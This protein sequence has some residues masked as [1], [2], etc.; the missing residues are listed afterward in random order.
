MLEMWPHGDAK[1]PGLI[2]GIAASSEEV[3]K[4]YNISSAL[5][6]AHMM[7]QF[8]HECSAGGEMK[9]NIRYSASRATQVWPSRFDDAEDCYRKCDSY[10]GDPQFHIKLIDH[11]YGGRMGNRP[12]PSHDGSQY[13]GM[14]LSQVT[15][16]EGYERLAAKTGLDLLDN[17]QL[18]IDP[19]HTLECGVADFIICGCLPYAE[20]DNLK[21]VTQRLNGG[22]IGAAERRAWLTHWK[23]ELNEL[24]EQKRSVSGGARGSDSNE[25]TYNP[26][27]VVA[28]PDNTP[29]TSD[30]ATIYVDP[31]PEPEKVT[32][33]SRFR[34]G[35]GGS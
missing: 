31:T 16:R 17:P 26:E 10:A 12:Y 25:P 21:M 15:G 27:R 33:L 30:T 22:Q 19:K 32:W 9:E 7:A 5:V 13:I 34:T 23:A 24:L 14:G 35:W 8:S 3:F 6:V 11:V 18:I 29:T 4:K 20:Q 2:E 1:V 28:T